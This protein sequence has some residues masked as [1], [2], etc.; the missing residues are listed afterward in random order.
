MIFNYNYD[1]LSTGAG[2]AIVGNMCSIS[3]DKCRI[4][5]LIYIR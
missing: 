5:M 2:D 4:N 1:E 3:I